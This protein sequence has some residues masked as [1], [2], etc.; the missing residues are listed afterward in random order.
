[1]RCSA[2]L[3]RW[4]AARVGTNA[5]AHGEGPVEDRAQHYRWAAA[6]AGGVAGGECGDP[7]GDPGRDPAGTGCEGEGEGAGDGA[8]AERV[9]SDCAERG[10]AAGAV[11]EHG[12]GEG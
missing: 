2:G 7:V 12:L 11:R 9:E 6:G 5:P 8:D 1:M 10:C 3:F 4:W